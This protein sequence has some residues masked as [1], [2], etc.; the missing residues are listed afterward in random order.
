MIIDEWV[1]HILNTDFNVLDAGAIKHA[2]K[3]IVDVVGCMVGGTK[4]PGG[5]VLVDLAR[6]WGGRGEATVAVY[7]LK[8]PA[9]D[10]AMINCVLGR[11]FDYGPVTPWIEGKP[12]IGHI[13]ESTIPAALTMAEWRGATG[14]EMLAALVLGDDITA[15]LLAAGDKGPP[16]AWEFTGIANVF[17]TTAVAGRL[18]G[19]NAAQ[20]A[21]AFGIG[22]NQMGGSMQ[23]LYEGALTFKL[24]QGLAARA[25]IFSAEMAGRGFTGIADPLLSKY[26]YF[27]L[28]SPAFDP[29]ILTRELGTR[30]YSDSTFKMYPCCAASHPTI[31]CVLDLIRKHSIEAGE[32]DE[33]TINVTPAHLSQPLG[34]PYLIGENT[35]GNAPFNLSYI[36][37][38]T[39]IRKGVK[40]EYFTEPF[41][42]DADVIK[43]SRE[44]HLTG[45]IP[46]EKHVTSAEIRVK[47]KDGKMLRARVDGPKGNPLNPMTDAEIKQ[48]FFENT[49]GII[50][51]GN[52][53]AAFDMINNLEE[54][55]DVS[56]L[57]RLLVV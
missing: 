38:S 1:K 40:P 43:L 33:I 34:Q 31:E 7:G 10:V 52:A 45:T 49:A 51:A 22:L 29:G 36:A 56:L 13:S 2:K 28:Y 32:L 11:S 5:S 53:T 17:G 14:K 9:H 55:D 57:V 48:K 25:G 54:V 26:G 46:N 15:R 20:M 24:P 18:L 37:A 3:R 23:N 12:V 27:A 8:A 16:G 19:L 35:R 21:D 6:Q 39:L 50:P 42:R 4:A 47:L 30:F 41:V 44:I